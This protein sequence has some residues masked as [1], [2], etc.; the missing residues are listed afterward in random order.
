MN[1]YLA[2]F[3]M[4]MPEKPVVKRQRLVVTETW[5]YVPAGRRGYFKRQEGEY[6]WIRLDEPLA[7]TF[8]KHIG[9]NLHCNVKVHVSC[10]RELRTL[11][12]LAECAE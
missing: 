2:G 5:R 12:L 11:E 7:Y 4:P 9:R 6:V 10:V 8:G 1:G 3:R